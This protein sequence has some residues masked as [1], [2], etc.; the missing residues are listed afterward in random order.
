MMPLFHIGGKVRNLLSPMLSGRGVIACSGFDAVLLW[1]ILSSTPSNESFTWYYAAPTIHHAII[2]ESD[3]QI[4]DISSNAVMK[5]RQRENVN[6]IRFVA[7]AAGVLPPILA[8]ELRR[9]FPKAVILT[10]YGMTECMSISIP[11]QNYAMNPVGTSS[12]PMGPDIII[13][14]E[15][16][17][18]VLRIGEV[19]EIPP[20]LNSSHIY[21]YLVLHFYIFI[22]F[23]IY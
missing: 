5:E 16:H 23:I 11:T 3:R 22:I 8:D 1:D 17:S 13:T 12:Q 10:S 19:R 21:V 14:D 18:K 7:N 6:T 2:Q 20:I 9:I 4:H 15:E